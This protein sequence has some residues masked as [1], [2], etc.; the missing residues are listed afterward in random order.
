MIVTESF[1]VHGKVQG[2]MFRQTFVR[3]L[4]KRG[5]LGGATNN[6]SN[7]NEVSCSVKGDGDIIK[8]LKEQLLSLESLNSWGAKVEEIVACEYIPYENCEVTTENV[9]SKKWTPGV[10]FYL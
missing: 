3:A 8:E 1:L 9:N 10:E 4:L 5:L 6:K 7:Q 2:I